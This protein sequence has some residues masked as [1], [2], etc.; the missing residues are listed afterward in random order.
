MPTIAIGSRTVPRPGRAS[1]ASGRRPVVTGCG[2]IGMLAT[3]AAAVTSPLHV[4]ACAGY[5]RAA[6]PAMTLTKDCL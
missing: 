5:R 4:R 6:K 2:A 3:G 1:D